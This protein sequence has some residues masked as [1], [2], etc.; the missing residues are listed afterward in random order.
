MLDQV[1]GLTQEIVELEQAL[2]RIPSV[3]TGAMPTGN[4]TPVAEYIRDWLGNEGISSEILA[5]D[6]ERG[7]IIAVYSGDLPRTRLMLMSHTDVVP[8]EEAEKWEHEPFGAEISG[9]RV[10]GRGASD[11][12]ALLTSQLMAMAV[13]ETERR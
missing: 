13:S 5:R 1:D 4:E 3:N 10:Y 8:V 7:N 9:G 11:C 6:P 12:K 2:V